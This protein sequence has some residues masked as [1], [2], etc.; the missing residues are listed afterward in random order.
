M[1]NVSPCGL[2]RRQKR[3]KS[4]L[5][6]NVENPSWAEEPK[7]KG[8]SKSPQIP[9]FGAE[10][11]RLSSNSKAAQAC[12]EEGARQEPGGGSNLDR[13]P[14]RPCRKAGR[15]AGGQL[16]ILEDRRKRC[17]TRW[18]YELPWWRPLGRGAQAESPRCL[19]LTSTKTAL[20]DRGF[21]RRRRGGETLAELEKDRAG[22]SASCE[23][24]TSPLKRTAAPASDQQKEAERLWTD[25]ANFKTTTYAVAWALGWHLLLRA[26]TIRRRAARRHQRIEGAD[27]TWG[28]LRA[29][30][31]VLFFTKN[32]PNWGESTRFLRR[33]AAQRRP[34]APVPRLQA[35]L[36]DAP[37]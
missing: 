12:L 37:A 13:G 33:G 8:L 27:G 36:S 18:N 32:S 2:C 25:V 29:G 6:R 30:R 16:Q 34:L 31:Y 35:D 19:R 7:R 22:C 9:C 11:C 24:I 15:R 3:A 28:A 26:T 4:P 10:S 5:V 1:P 23:S 17:P 21:S 20:S 14:G